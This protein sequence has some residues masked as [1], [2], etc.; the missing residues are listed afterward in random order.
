M[1]SRNVDFI[2]ND[3]NISI[4]ANIRRI[5]LSQ[6]IGQTRLVTLM[7]L[8]GINITRQ[9]LVKIETGTQHVKASQFKAIKEILNTSYDELLKEKA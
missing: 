8:K 5:R 3:E 6:N 7:Q 9:T 2:K 1:K 4:G